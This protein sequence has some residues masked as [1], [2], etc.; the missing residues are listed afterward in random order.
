MSQ[1]N[2]EVAK[3]FIEAY[4]AEAGIESAL[5]VFPPD[6]VVYAFPEWVEKSEYR[7]HDGVREL[8]AVWTESFDDFA[9]EV[10]EVRDL[11]DRVVILGE[12]T[13]RI[14]GT[15]VPI[16]QPVGA[17]FSNFRNGKIGEARFFMTK[18]QTLEAAGLGE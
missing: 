15:G 1:E 17:V 16:R 7:G 3:K 13:G 4:A 6:A 10:E 2:V 11:G 5:S 12:T 8:T 18:Q 14:K 9:I